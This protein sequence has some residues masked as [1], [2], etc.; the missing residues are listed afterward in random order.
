MDHGVLRVGQPR[1]RWYTTT[2]ADLWKD[3][4]TTTVDNSIRFAG[5]NNL[6]IQQH[7]D[8]SKQHAQTITEKAKKKKLTGTHS[9]NSQNEGNRSRPGIAARGPGRASES[10]YIESSDA[11][12]ASDTDSYSA[13]T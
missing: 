4:K 5:I 10:V 6:S 2:L 13:L 1:K 7:V 8:A 3:T 12:S 9:G 11:S